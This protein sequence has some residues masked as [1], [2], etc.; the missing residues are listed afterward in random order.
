MKLKAFIL[1]FVGVFIFVFAYDWVFHGII[2]KDAYAA[3][4]ALWRPE[5][6]M[7]SYF[8]WIVV[9]QALSAFAITILVA[10]AAFGPKCGLGIGGLVGLVVVAGN[11]IGYAVQPIP[12]NL[13][14]AWSISAVIQGSLAGGVAGLLY[15][16]FGGKSCCQK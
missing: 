3:T 2:L 10:R 15:F 13:T 4:M 14:L 9:G 8:K 11:L 12:A 7:A 16:K 5:A 6:E 1:A